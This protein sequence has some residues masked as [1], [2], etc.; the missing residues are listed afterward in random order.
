M[1]EV[2]HR[3]TLVGCERECGDVDRAGFWMG[4]ILGK[5]YAWTVREDSQ[6]FIDVTPYGSHAEAISFFDAL[7]KAVA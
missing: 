5:R 6:G 4:L 3:V 1:A 2:V 7:E